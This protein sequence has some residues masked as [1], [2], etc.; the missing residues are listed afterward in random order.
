MSNSDTF[1]TLKELEWISL[2][3]VLDTAINISDKYHI[4]I[5]KRCIQRKEK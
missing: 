4:A 1:L 3:L 2:S 5:T